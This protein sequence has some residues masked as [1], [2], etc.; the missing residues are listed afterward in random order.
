VK[1]GI[2]AIT[3]SLGSRSLTNEELAAENPQWDMARTFE[4]T[5]IISR[6]VAEAS[7]T[8]LDLGEKASF[9]LFKQVGI[10]A[11]EID[12]LIFCT[13]TPDYV[14]PPNSTLLHGRLA[15]PQNVMAFDINHACS[16]FIYGLGIGQSLIKSDTA[17]RVLLV[18]GDTYT[19]LLHP[20]DRATRPIFGDGAAATLITGEDPVVSVIDMTFHTGG[21]VADRFI[22]KRGGARNPHLTNPEP[23]TIDKSGRVRSDGHVYMDGLGVLSFFTSVVPKAVREIL[24]RNQMSMEDI[25][26]FVFHQASQLALDGLQ[27]SLAIPDEKMVVDI[28]DTGNLVSS[29]I[30]VALSRVLKDRCLKPDQLVLL[31]GFGVGLSWATALVRF[32]GE[33]V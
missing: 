4:R 32:N 27:K 1:L 15:M 21:K 25:S 30:P 13:Q 31:C 6:P 20:Q 16:G 11:N 8:A 9:A 5:G 24:S 29:S 26:L 33:K 10:T 22:V 23:E 28:Q 14:L 7:E 19:R 17:K 18:T 12:A 2:N 3:Y